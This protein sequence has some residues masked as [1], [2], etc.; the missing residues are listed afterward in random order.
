[1]EHDIKKKVA[2]SFVWVSVSSLLSRASTIVATL[3]LAGLLSPDDFGVVAIANVISAALGLF[4]DLG[5]N[6]AL[7]YQKDHIEDA[8]DTAM[9]LSVAISAVLFGIGYLLAEP[10]A[11]FVRYPDVE[12]V[13]KVLPFS[14]VITAFS[15]IPTSLLEKEMDFKKRALPEIVSFFTYFV[16]SVTLALMGFAYW[17]IVL[18]HIAH[19]IVNLIVVFIISPWHP[20]FRFH[21]RILKGLLGFGKY[22]MSNTIIVFIFRNV[23]DFSI[24]R[25]LGTASLGFYNLAYRISNVTATQITHMISKV[26][27]PAMVKMKDDSKKIIDFYLKTFYYLSIIN[28]PLATGI[29]CFASPFFHIFYG[30]KWDAAILPTQILA[31]FGLLRGL[32]SSAGSV[33]MTIGR[34]RETF[35]V[36]L[37]QLILLLALIYPV[38][39]N[40]EVVGLCILLTLLNV[41]M[42]LVFTLRLESLFPNTAK[43]TMKLMTPP[44]IFSVITILLPIKLLTFAFGEPDLSL[45]I[46]V[47]ISSCLLY[48]FA[49]TRRDKDILREIKDL[50]FSR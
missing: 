4:R 50:F 38:I 8:S 40:F 1:L 2:S 13:I 10:A 41:A 11:G 36:L 14:L 19:S 5:M 24:G 22:A 43:R 20:S 15:S 12:D 45:F 6:Q 31:V 34:I 37:G 28:F 23:D 39:I 49:I 32:F 3:I 17:S 47:A 48:L 29:I 26:T 18:G 33:F 16:V 9:I 25:L 35:F 27:F 7:I 46:G 21:P 44:L 30:N 42:A